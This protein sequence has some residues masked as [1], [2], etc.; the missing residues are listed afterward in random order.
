M[1]FFH[2]RRRID[3]S[4]KWQ[5]WYTGP[6]MVIQ[7]TGPVNYCLQRTKRSMPFTVHVDKLK[8]C[9]QG[10]LPSWITESEN[11]LGYAGTDDPEDVRQNAEAVSHTDGPNRPLTMDGELNDSDVNKEH[12]Q[13]LRRSERQ[14]RIPARYRNGHIENSNCIVNA[15][16]FVTNHSIEHCLSQMDVQLKTCYQCAATYHSIK[17][18][19]SHIRAV[20]R[21]KEIQQS[22]L[23]TVRESS[24]SYT[25]D[26]EIKRQADIAEFRRA[27]HESQLQERRRRLEKLV[28]IVRGWNE[29]DPAIL[30]NS[31]S[32]LMLRMKNLPGTDIQSRDALLAI[33]LT[34]RAFSQKST[35]TDTFPVP[36]P[37]PEGRR[38][39]CKLCNTPAEPLEK[40]KLTGAIVRKHRQK[41]PNLI[42]D[43]SCDKENGTEPKISPV[44]GDSED[45]WCRDIWRTYA[46]KEVSW[47]TGASDTSSSSDDATWGP[48]SP[49]SPL[50][51]GYPFSWY[52]YFKDSDGKPLK[53]HSAQWKQ[54]RDEWATARTTGTG[55]SQK[56]CPSPRARRAS[57]ERYKH[58]LRCLHTGLTYDWTTN[59][60]RPIQVSDIALPPKSQSPKD[61][62]PVMKTPQPQPL[63]R[64]HRCDS[65]VTKKP[66][67]TH[68]TA[69]FDDIDEP[70]IELDIEV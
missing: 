69:D 3:R 49:E 59:Q 50:T 17:A 33:V 60:F 66:K 6:F 16:I 40:T 11:D 27:W 70:V 48:D 56:R 64:S 57:K 42:T 47:P 39:D 46:T 62:P 32:E 44:E 30:T 41:T 18:L 15:R 23:D 25:E 43:N 38:N 53:K 37:H 5:K 7:Q 58:Q 34:A 36:L 61:F 55:E 19:R 9:L 51:A 29:Q 10:H 8:P 13:R 22:N 21:K 2:P 67:G 26:D 65:P 28:T 54:R 1:W 4:P 24:C 45:E 63:S 14:R 35:E 12:P 68:P 20:H 52:S 31:T